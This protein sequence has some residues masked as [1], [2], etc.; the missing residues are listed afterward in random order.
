[1]NLSH[2]HDGTAVN[3]RISKDHYFGKNTE[4]HYPNLDDLVKIIQKKGRGALLFKRDLLK[5]YR[6]IYMDPGSIHLLGFVV[7]G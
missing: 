1:M 3:A 6:Q 4:L 5:C 2:P 7:Q